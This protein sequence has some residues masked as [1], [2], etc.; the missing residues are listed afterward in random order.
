[1]LDSVAQCGAFDEFKNEEPYTF[2]FFETV[3][4][5]NVGVVQR[6]QQ[7]RF[8]FKPRKS[9]GVLSEL[10]RQCLDRNFTPE[11]GVLGLEV[12]TKGV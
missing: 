11:F 7:L 5:C 10:F 2:L 8:T 9:V 1:M 6:C 4:C 3:D 12:I